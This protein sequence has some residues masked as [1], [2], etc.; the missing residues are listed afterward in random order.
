[1]RARVGLVRRAALRGS[2]VGQHPQADHHTA[3]EIAQAEAGGHRQHGERASLIRKAGS[4]GWARRDLHYPLGGTDHHQ[5]H[6]GTEVGQPSQLLLREALWITR[7]APYVHRKAHPSLRLGR[8]NR[9]AQP[10]PLFPAKRVTSCHAHPQ[11]QSRRSPVTSGRCALGWHRGPRRLPGCRQPGAHPAP[12]G[13]QGGSDQR[14]TRCRT[15]RVSPPS[16]GQD[17]SAEHLARRMGAGRSASAPLTA[18]A[19]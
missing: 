8:R 3:H 13:A 7:D 9:L 16:R 6:G 14:A 17:G 2:R 19:G 1:M 10:E 15:M 4:G 12:A 18:P 5:R 11:G